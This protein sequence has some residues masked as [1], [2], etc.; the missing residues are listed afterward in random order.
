MRRLAIVTALLLTIVVAAMAQ[1]RKVTPVASTDE[2][3][4]VTKEELKEIHRQEKLK[5]LR[6]DSITLDSLRRD[7][8]E[9]AS[10][11][12]YRPT[13]M[14]I[15]VGVNFWGPLMR[16]LGQDYGDCDVWAAV[17]IKNRYI[18]VAEVGFGQANCSPDDGN[19]T[20]KGKLALYGKVG[21][22]YNFMF[23][24]DTKYQLYAGVRFAAS[25]FKY[26]I[27]GASVNN[28]YWGKDPSTF[29]LR[30]QSSS[31][32]W[33]EFVAGIQVELFKNFSMGWAVRY[34]FPF[35]IKDLPN[36]RPYYIPGYGVRD[37]HLNVSLSVAYTLPLHRDK[38]KTPVTTMP[39]VQEEPQLDNV[40][41]PERKEE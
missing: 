37:N 26:D 6:T 18:P 35:S 1:Q 11:R 2:L 25:K 19:F 41:V 17:N 7:S 27:T 21:M 8:I 10:K 22:N 14:G 13:L 15:T 3:K 36:S 5:F 39:P 16:A 24:K 38:P 32:F 9:R 23:A 34:N 12:V 28:G 31:A 40:V 29:D 20:Y 33:G 30:D 4:P